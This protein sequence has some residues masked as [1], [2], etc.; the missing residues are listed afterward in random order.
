MDENPTEWAVAT[1]SVRGASHVRDGRPNQDA[2]LAWVD[3]D[4]RAR[5]VLAVADGHGSDNSFRSDV[6]SVLAVE[7]AVNVAKGF[8]LNTR[9]LPIGQVKDAAERH[10]PVDISKAWLAA[11]TDHVGR[12]PYTPAER[13][14]VD[15]VGSAGRDVRPYGS[16]LLLVVVAEAFVAYLQLGDGDLT[17]VP[18]GGTGRPAVA[19]DPTL[20]ANETTSLCMDKAHR[21]FRTRFVPTREGQPPRL[22]MAST[23]G[24]SN[25]FAGGDDFLKVASDLLSAV[26]AEGVAAVEAELPGW[27]NEASAAGSGDDVTVGLLYRIDGPTA[28]S[29]ASDTP[30]ET[31]DTPREAHE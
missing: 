12:N 25:S 1:A 19:A 31:S 13:G 3:P 10:V 26:R 6:G 5:A 21:L 20:M 30:H 17:V 11:V 9:D 18:D 14:R 29:P 22:V 4:R 15:R 27:L 2:V 8:L 28:P 23:D 7:V 24:Y 16:T